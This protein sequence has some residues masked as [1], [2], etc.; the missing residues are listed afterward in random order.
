MVGMEEMEGRLELMDST[1]R[2]GAV[3]MESLEEMKAMEQMD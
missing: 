1:D 2:V 3:A